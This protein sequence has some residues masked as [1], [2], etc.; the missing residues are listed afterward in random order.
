MYARSSLARSGKRLAQ[1]G[2][3]ILQVLIGT[4]VGAIALVAAV[5]AVQGQRAEAQLNEAFAFIAN[6]MSQALSS[7]YYSNSRSYAG[8]T[9]GISGDADNPITA[10]NGVLLLTTRLGLRNEMPWGED[11][12]A[13]TSDGTSRNEVTMVFDCSAIGANAAVIENRCTQLANS[14][15]NAGAQ[16][17]TDDAG[18]GTCT[19]DNGEQNITCVYRRPL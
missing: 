6:E 3:N 2:V 12:W 14:I 16:Q 18:D 19:Y 4:V 8:L 11:W 15:N 10:T 7:Y 1:K 13:I 9:A 17:L 5:N